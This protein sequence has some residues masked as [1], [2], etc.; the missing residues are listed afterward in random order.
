MPL[1]EMQY[2]VPGQKDD[3]VKIRGYRIERGRGREHTWSERRAWSSA[4]VLCKT[5]KGSPQINSV[6]SRSFDRDENS[7]Y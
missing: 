7:S 6:Y 3:Q 1:A 2:R 4:P 5:R